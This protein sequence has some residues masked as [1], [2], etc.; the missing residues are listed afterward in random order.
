MARLLIL[1]DEQP[2][3]QSLQLVLQRAGHE[4]LLVE[5][6]RDAYQRLEQESVDLALL[7]VQLPDGSGLDVLRKLRAEAPEVPALVVTAYASVDT[8]VEAMKAGA[9][10]Y[11]E[12]PLDLEEL[13]MVVQ[14]ELDNARLRG[15]VE[16]Y[17]RQSKQ[18]VQGQTILGTSAAADRVRRFIDQVSRL[19]VERAADL[20]TILLE[21]ETGSGKDLIA[22]TI[23]D[24]SPVAERPFVDINCAGLPRELVESELFG[25]ERGSFSGADRVKRGLFEVAQGGTI[26]LNEIGD[27]PLDLQAKLLT[28]LESRRIRRVGG[29]REHPVQVRILAATNRDLEAAVA[30][31][32]FRS[33]LFYRLRVM[34]LKVPPL[35]ERMDDVPALAEH[36]LARLCTKYGRPELSLTRDDVA[37][38]LRWHWPGN[39]RELAH[40]LESMVLTADGDRLGPPPFA[41]VASGA[42]VGRR[43]YDFDHEDCTMQTLQRDLIEQALT[44]ADGNVS[45]VARML[46]LTRGALRHKMEKLGISGGNG[47]DSE[48]TG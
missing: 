10:D 38:L 4:C 44:H 7:D 33:D 5:N 28:T 42:T 13:Q 29:T 9:I 11:L 36:F 2:L 35:R 23:H 15:E 17:R 14:R 34:H 1:D 30:D 22:R 16:A 45:Q 27:M 47:D 41:S 40:T 43:E 46:D 48:R 37:A 26:F 31:Q 21:G 39:V 18:R 8:A 12:K 20:P 6:V 24:S 19:P 25:H 32:K 3:L